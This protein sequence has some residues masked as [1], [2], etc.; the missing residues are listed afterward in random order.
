[1]PH[2]QKYPI[3]W[4]PYTKKFQSTEHI[5]QKSIRLFYCR[6]GQGYQNLDEILEPKKEN[7]IFSN[8]INNPDNR[9][10]FFKR[11]R[12]FVK[13]FPEDEKIISRAKKKFVKDLTTKKNCQRFKAS[14]RKRFEIF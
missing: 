13:N 3:K 10:F 7:E 1:M 9:I 12:D 8:N 11:I 5:N 4:T 6:F 2:S 14:I